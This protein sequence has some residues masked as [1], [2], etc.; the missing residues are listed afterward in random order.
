MT[1]RLLACPLT[2]LAMEKVI[3]LCT[4]KIKTVSQTNYRYPCH[5]LVGHRSR[6]YIGHECSQHVSCAKFH[7]PM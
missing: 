1:H 6:T 4:N 2:D 5:L 7:V 3:K